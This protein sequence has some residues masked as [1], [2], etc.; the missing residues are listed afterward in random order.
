M[1]QFSYSQ[2]FQLLTISASPPRKDILE[3]GDSKFS[4]PRI[5]SIQRNI[6]SSS[7]GRL[8][9]LPSEILHMVFLS[10]PLSSLY[11][12]LFCSAGCRM[13]I[14]AFPE[15]CDLRSHNPGII[16]A[17]NATLLLGSFSISRYTKHSPALCVQHANGLV[18][19]CFCLLLHAFVSFV[20]KRYSISCLFHDAWRRM[21]I[22]S[23]HQRS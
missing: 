19:S 11:A 3:Y 8:D 12:L 20:R 15:Y 2:N 21:N 17:L 10:L 14:L 22:A 4:L 13:V 23:N 16:F 1:G 9:I 18:D 6:L 5:K 7:L